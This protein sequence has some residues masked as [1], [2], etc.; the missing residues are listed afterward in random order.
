MIKLI[1]L[2]LLLVSLFACHQEPSH[3][4][5]DDA[6]VSEKKTVPDSPLV[7]TA[8]DIIQVDM[9]GGVA[10]LDTTSGIFCYVNM[11][12]KSGGIIVNKEMVQLVNFTNDNGS[13]SFTGKDIVITTTECA[14]DEMTTDCAYGTFD[15]VTVE[16]A[17]KTAYFSGITLQDCSSL[18]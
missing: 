8:I 4:T 17:G 14:Y 15:R 2:V 12:T 1:S 18:E 7:I 5:I 9:Y 13:Y 10:L 3:Q 16:M 11:K 6:T